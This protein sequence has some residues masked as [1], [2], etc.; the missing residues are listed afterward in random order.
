M[1]DVD[2]VGERG[3]DQAGHTL[4]TGQTI[5][6]WQGEGYQ[7]QFTVTM[8]GEEYQR[9][10]E[11]QENTYVHVCTFKSQRFNTHGQQTMQCTINPRNIYT[12]V[13]IAPVQCSYYFALPLQC[14]F[15]CHGASF[16]QG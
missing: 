13:Y 9:H 14:L 1:I 5:V 16:L 3:V 10:Y 12:Y 4:T 2:L 11:Y 7:H 8:Q 15:M 6:T